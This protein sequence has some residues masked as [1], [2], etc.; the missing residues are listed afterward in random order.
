MLFL[1]LVAHQANQVQ[2]MSRLAGAF[3]RKLDEA[4]RFGTTLVGRGSDDGARATINS[5]D[6]L[7][8]KFGTSTRSSR[9][10]KSMKE[11]NVPEERVMQLVEG[12]NRFS[13][14]TKSVA[15]VWK[16]MIDQMRSI[17]DDIVNVFRKQK[18]AESLLKKISGESESDA[19]DLIKKQAEKALFESDN[20]LEK[21]KQCKQ[22]RKKMEGR[23][24]ISQNTE[25]LSAAEKRV[26]KS[27]QKFLDVLEENEVLFK[28]RR[29]VNKKLLIKVENNKKVLDLKLNVAKDQQ[30]FLLSNADIKQYE[31][32]M[33]RID[34]DLLKRNIKNATE[35]Y[36]N[37]LAKEF[38]EILN[39]IG[40]KSG[41]TIRTDN[42]TMER[43]EQLSRYE[44]MM[45]V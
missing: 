6:S 36:L 31:R 35:D 18:K 4:L 15:T 37:N 28:K 30:K 25:I 27:F 14:L 26:N 39:P 40:S 23:I 43:L 44:D 38:P 34:S 13:A 16:N 41:A 2:A 5:V 3:S 21:L 1:V 11:I 10:A 33:S 8:D 9:T 22:L 7:A 20:T 29:E 19:L 45:T 24:R 12:Q 42:A 32:E 17:I